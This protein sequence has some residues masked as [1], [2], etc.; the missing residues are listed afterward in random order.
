MTETSAVSHSSHY[1]FSHTHTLS[2]SANCREDL[3]SELFLQVLY[4]SADGSHDGT[5]H[6]RQDQQRYLPTALLAS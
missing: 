6:R 1:E 2:L 3:I 4:A 5:D